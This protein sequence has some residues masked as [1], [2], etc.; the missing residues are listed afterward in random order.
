MAIS[1]RFGRG[2]RYPV[3]SPI[4]KLGST[5]ESSE[6]EPLGGM[7]WHPLHGRVTDLHSISVISTIVN[8]N[9]W[10]QPLK[11]PHFRLAEDLSRFQDDEFTQ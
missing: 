4:G 10:K 1:V 8:G 11:L 9:A 2:G 3:L 6:A 5:Y 7:T